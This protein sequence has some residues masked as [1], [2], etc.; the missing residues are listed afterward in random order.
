MRTGTKLE[1]VISV[2]KKVFDDA[3]IK[4]KNKQKR[5]I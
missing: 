5:Y 2:E 4:K 3:I 1:H